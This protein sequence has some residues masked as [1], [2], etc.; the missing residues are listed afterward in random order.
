MYYMQYT[1]THTH[2]H[3]HIL[4]AH[5]LSV[6]LGFG[7]SVKKADMGSLEA[8]FVSMAVVSAVIRITDMDP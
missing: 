3:T 8:S 7:S 5:R 2:T 4:H 6:H 1:H